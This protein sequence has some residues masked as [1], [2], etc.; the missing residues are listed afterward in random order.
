MTD[1]DRP[2]MPRVAPATLNEALYVAA[3]R[4]LGKYNQENKA[5]D[6]LIEIE[7]L[8]ERL[9]FRDLGGKEGDFSPAS[10]AARLHLTKLWLWAYDQSDDEIYPK[11]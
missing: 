10:Q 2:E 7:T 6:D 9:C 8:A 5:L 4:A 1:M 11:I 3:V